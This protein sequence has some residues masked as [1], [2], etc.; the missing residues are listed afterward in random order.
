MGIKYHVIAHFWEW[1][2][3]QNTVRYWQIASFNNNLQWWSQQQKEIW[4]HC[5]AIGPKR[6]HVRHPPT[7]EFVYVRIARRKDTTPIVHIIPEL[8]TL[9]V[10]WW[11]RGV[12]THLDFLRKL[13]STMSVY[14]QHNHYF[15]H[16]GRMCCAR[17]HRFSLRLLSHKVP[18]AAQFR[19][20]KSKQW[21]HDST[22]QPHN[23]TRQQH[24]SSSRWHDSTMSLKYL[25][26]WE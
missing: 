11:T 15:S 17:Y 5:G 24:D 20:Q 12:V 3:T 13:W 21:R 23:S 16:C 18:K 22:L 19:R 1:S 2:T 25:I 4:S 26:T 9:P 8:Q 14:G 10:L 6:S 7:T